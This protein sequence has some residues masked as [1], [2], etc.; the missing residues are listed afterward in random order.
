MRFLH[1]TNPKDEDHPNYLYKEKTPEQINQIIKEQIE[2]LKSAVKTGKHIFILIYQYGCPPCNA[3]RP[4][5][6]KLR[7]VRMLKGHDDIVVVDIDKEY[8]DKLNGYIKTDNIIGFPTMRYI[9][10]THAENFEDFD[11]PDQERKRNVAI[12]SKW[13]MSKSGARETPDTREKTAPFK[14]K[15]N[16]SKNLLKGGGGSSKSRKH[17]KRMQ[18]GGKWSLKYKRSINCNRPKGFSQ[19]QHCKSKR[20]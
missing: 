16:H 1:I 11:I 17:K 12:F 4:E 10:G 15:N 5:W 13:I 3:T 9:K 6:Q 7:K 18:R 14:S 20:K 2:E 8:N 19:K